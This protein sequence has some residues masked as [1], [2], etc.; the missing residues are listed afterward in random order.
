MVTI[1]RMTPGGQLPVPKLPNELIVLCAFDRDD[2][3]ICTPLS[4]LERCRT[5]V[6]Q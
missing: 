4:N 3:R 5:N 2:E 1:V 6:G